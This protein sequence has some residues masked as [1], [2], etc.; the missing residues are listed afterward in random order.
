[1]KLTDYPHLVQL[2]KEIKSLRYNSKEY[3]E[4]RARNR[5]KMDDP[6]YTDFE[7]SNCRYFHSIL[8]KKEA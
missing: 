6:S 2:E 3:W 1:M 4:A 7:R 8:V 5:E